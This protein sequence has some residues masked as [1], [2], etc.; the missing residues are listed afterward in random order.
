MPN[1][2]GLL[3]ASAALLGAAC[4]GPSAGGEGG[5]PVVVAA[6]YPLEFAAARIGGTAV[7]VKGLTPP[8]A[9]PHDLELTSGQVRDLAE[10]DLVLYVGGG[11]QP[12]L[13]D[14]V[15]GI[16]DSRKLD[17]LEARELMQGEGEEGDDAADPHVW[18]DPTRLA[19]IADEI[20]ARLSEVDPGN[21]E[22]FSDNA[23]QL[24]EDLRELDEDFA[25]GL[26]DCRSKEIVTSHEAFGYLAARYGI[27]Q[28]GISGIDPEAEPSAERLA[29]IAELVEERGVDT[30][31]F[32]ELAPPDLAETL[33]RETGAQ[34]AVLSP[35]ETAPERGDYLDAMR[36]NLE[37]LREA[38]DCV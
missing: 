33:A 21:A 5:R 31:F 16:D 38:L 23:A 34:T 30:I 17:V 36:A 10:T 27:D 7:E 4:G 26:R 2:L 35:L 11:F 24:R 15:A 14:A 8:G 12:A 3:C 29:E 22:L 19:E 32:E 1:R 18:L 28:V 37:R 6:F 25:D 9:E 13:E 20:A